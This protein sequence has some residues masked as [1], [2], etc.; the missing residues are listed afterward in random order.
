MT[1][2][3]QSF[4]LLYLTN[5]PDVLVPACN[6]NV[7]ACRSVIFSTTGTCE[8]KPP[9]ATDLISDAGRYSG[10]PAFNLA[11]GTL[12][13]KQV[14]QEGVRKPSEV[15]IK[16]QSETVFPVEPV[17]GLV[18]ECFMFYVV[19]YVAPERS[20]VGSCQLN[21]ACHPRFSEDL[22]ETI[23]AH[24][25]DRPSGLRVDLIKAP[26]ATKPWE[27]EP[28]DTSGSNIVVADF[29]KEGLKASG[30]LDESKG[31]TE[32]ILDVVGCLSRELHQFST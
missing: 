21:L 22:D 5:N 31:A 32:E 12:N 29:S 23:P 14:S 17:A 27:L 13:A 10:F 11:D 15:R 25:A 6:P 26:I 24:L 19:I 3:S 7:Q 18:S 30:F 4:V 8:P 28:L 2:D 9:S 16:L 20:P 1:Y